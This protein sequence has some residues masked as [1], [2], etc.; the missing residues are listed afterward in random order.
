MDEIN[1]LLVDDQ[2]D[3]LFII[4]GWLKSP[5]IAF[6]EASSGREALEIAAN[7][8]WAL[9]IMDVQMP[10]M[11]GFET[12]NAIRNLEGFQKVPII[13]VS[14]NRQS[15]DS[16]FQGYSEGGVDYLLRPINPHILK[17]KVQIFVELYQQ[18]R[19]IENRNEQMR[20]DLKLASEFQREILPKISHVPFL[21]I[22]SQYKPYGEVSGDLYDM[23]FNREG[24]LNIFLGDAT[25][26]GT[27]AAF[28]TMM[29][30]IGLD[31][32]QTNLSTDDAIRSLNTLLAT[33]DTGKSITGIYLRIA[34]TGELSA[35]R[36]GHPPLVI[37]PKDG[38]ALVL[39]R[40]GGCALG[41]FLEVM[42]PYVEETYELKKGDKVLL[43]TDAVI[44]WM[45]QN[46]KPYSLDR[47]I[48][49]LEEHRTT[50]IEKMLTEILSELQRFSQGIPCGDDLTMLGFEFCGK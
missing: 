48:R 27:S 4:K 38:S 45:D 32:L 21:K 37:I 9:V 30:Q 43:Y 6:Y 11:D 20:E 5:G 17:S 41:I 10:V 1:I 16:V 31:N 14:A 40:K 3:Q 36:A 50:E 22:T 46:K 19:E 13:F 39:L 23:R 49:F 12:A 18:K 44:E 15:D 25:G 47:F 26:H 42:V 34:P 7:H 33:R 35:T 29:L 24:A 8:E 2:P 28:M